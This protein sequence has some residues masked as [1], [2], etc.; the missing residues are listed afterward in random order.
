[1][2]GNE[3]TWLFLSRRRRFSPLFFASQIH[4]QQPI[5]HFLT[6]HNYLGLPFIFFF[7]Q[8]IIFLTE[9]WQVLSKVYSLTSFWLWAA[10]LVT[11]WLDSFGAV[12]AGFPHYFLHPEFINRNC[13]F[14]F[15]TGHNYLGL[16]FLFFFARWIIFPTELWQILSKVYSLTSFWLRGV[17]LVIQWVDSFWAVAVGSPY[18]FSHPKFI[19]S[20]QF[21]IS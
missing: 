5:F 12:A 20:N 13:F 9:L 1:M 7:A 4:K 2:N 14:H 3:K 6:R 10:S 8:W 21:F 15:L 18:C 11:Q 19:N 17:S 16:P